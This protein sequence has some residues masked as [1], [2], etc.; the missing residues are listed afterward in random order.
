MSENAVK[1]EILNEENINKGEGGE[2]KE[3]KSYGVILKDTFKSIFKYIRYFLKTTVNPFGA[4]AFI[5]GLVFILGYITFDKL[6]YDVG[7]TGYLILFLYLMTIAVGVTPIRIAF[8]NKQRK[9]SDPAVMGKFTAEILARQ[10][11]PVL[12]CTKEGI[13]V[14]MNKSFQQTV[15]SDNFRLKGQHMKTVISYAPEVLLNLEKFPDGVDVVLGEK[16]YKVKG[17]SIINAVPVKDGGKNKEKKIKALEEVKEIEYLAFV[18]SDVT[19]A[20]QARKA[21]IAER[22]LIANIKIDNLEDLLQFVEGNYKEV[23]SQVDAILRKWADS[24]NGFIKEYQ[25]DK[26]IFLFDAKYLDGFA[27]NQFSVLDEVRTIRVGESHTPVTISIGVSDPMGSLEERLKSAG[28]YL[29]TALQRGGDQAV[30]KMGEKI[31]Y[32]GGV[33][34][35]VQKRTKTRARVI[36]TEVGG[37]I[38]NSSN[39]IIMGHKNADYDSFGACIGMAILVRSFGKECKIV[40]NEQDPNLSKCIVKAKSIPGFENVF[41][42][43]F[44]AQELIRSDSLLIIVDVNN[45]YQFESKDIYENS[46]KT[47]FVDHHRLASKFEN[48]PEISYIEP[49]ASSTCE[50]ITELLEQTLGDSQI[51]KEEAEL[52]YAGIALDTKK[53]TVN[54]GTKT[55]SAAM[56]LRNCGADPMAVNQQL[57]ATDITELTR[58]A[59]FEHK[60]K[61]YRSV[62]AISVNEMEDLTME[63]DKYA[64]MAADKMLALEGVKASFTLCMINGCVRVKARSNGS[65]NVQL[66]IEQLGGGGHFDQAATVMSGI[67]LE[68]ACNLLKEAIDKS[69]EINPEK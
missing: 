53:F 15:G 21:M 56:Y 58:L 17:Y 49:S 55:F 46:H 38:K 50:L 33:T 6:G 23:Y 31:C 29:D 57:F 36:A 10:D 44:K 52:L 59:G 1:P 40:I 30:V 60:V 27:E 25:R 24:V 63:D 32:Y 67:D 9:E 19:E 45:P 61:I 51:S 64:A 18:F 16:N 54:S 2:N 3:N 65:I 22:T 26:Y 14:W 68:G 13:I 35:T 69:F 39:I 12:M 20:V 7:N 42:D 48:E 47:V 41:T 43:S 8:L 34:K 28:A 37:L 4:L 66:I 62:T 11:V 5:S